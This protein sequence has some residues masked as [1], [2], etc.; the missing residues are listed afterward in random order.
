MRDTANV[1]GHNVDA[2]GRKGRVGDG[3]REL[4]P[5]CNAADGPGSGAGR[6][7]NIGLRPQGRLD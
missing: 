5:V 6:E 3:F 1:S 2:Q 4:L 7:Q